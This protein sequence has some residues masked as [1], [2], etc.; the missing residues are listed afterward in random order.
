MSDL[1]SLYCLFFFYTAAACMANKVVY[2]VLFYL[3]IMKVVQKYT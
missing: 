1:L 3:F 2:I